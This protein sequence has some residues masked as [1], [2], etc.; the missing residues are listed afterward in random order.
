MVDRRREKHIPSVQS[1][2]GSAWRAQLC[3]RTLAAPLNTMEARFTNAQ[4]ANT[5]IALV[6][7]ELKR[8]GWDCADVST[9]LCVLKQIEQQQ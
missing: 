4:Q 5:A 1:S 7:N 3:R 9:V 8:L 2:S 6:R